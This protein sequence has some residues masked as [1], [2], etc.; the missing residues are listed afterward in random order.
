MK[1]PLDQLLVRVEL[2]GC[3]VAPV[4]VAALVLA[5]RRYCGLT[6]QMAEA[7][8]EKRALTSAEFD[9]LADRMEEAR[10]CVMP[11]LK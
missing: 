5:L 9:Q 6:A 8:A 4:H 10:T 1:I 11:D 2:S 7:L 3:A